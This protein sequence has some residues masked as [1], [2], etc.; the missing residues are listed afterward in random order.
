MMPQNPLDYTCST[1][2]HDQIGQTSTVNQQISNQDKAHLSLTSNSIY[3]V[4]ITTLAIPSKRVAVPNRDGH[5]TES[6]VRQAPTPE[7]LPLQQSNITNDI[8]TAIDQNDNNYINSDNSA[9]GQIRTSDQLKEMETKL[10]QREKALSKKEK[11][12]KK[13]EMD[14]SDKVTQMAARKA[15]IAKLETQIKELQK[16]NHLMKIHL[17]AS[18]STPDENPA[19]LRQSSTNVNTRSEEGQ[20]S[21]QCNCAN[22]SNQTPPLEQIHMHN[23]FKTM[24]C[25]IDLI[26]KTH[27]LEIQS[28]RMKIEQLENTQIE[29]KPHY[30]KNPKIARIIR[31]DEIPRQCSTME[32][33]I[34][35]H[36]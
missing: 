31:K 23:I 18:Q 15:Y 33:I 32:H 24:E 22:S 21:C 35:L 5:M 13:M 29:N 30:R 2:R 11:D 4:D 27:Q 14:Y 25:R 17:S 12:V 8:N 36:L 6:N 20:K 19:S 10:K 34:T 1:C 28:L 26:E 16:S 9:S 7:Q 3:G